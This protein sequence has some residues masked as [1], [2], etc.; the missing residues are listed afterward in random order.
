MCNL[1]IP[2]PL[3][4]LPSILPFFLF[5]FP[6]L[7]SP[8]CVVLLK[9]EEVNNA[10]ATVRSVVEDVDNLP[11]RQLSLAKEQLGLLTDRKK[12]LD[13]MLSGLLDEVSG[14]MNE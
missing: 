7:P 3:L 8:P 13:Q 1:T 10:I 6:V 11:A 5:P 2:R 9:A 4:L 12:D 14:G